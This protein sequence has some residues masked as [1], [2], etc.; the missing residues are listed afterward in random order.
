MQLM[1]VT[2]F[3]TKDKNNNLKFGGTVATNSH[4]KK[5]L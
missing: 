3:Q 2:I 1:C 4:F 5:Y